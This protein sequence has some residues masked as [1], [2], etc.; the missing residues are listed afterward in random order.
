MSPTVIVGEAIFKIISME[1]MKLQAEVNPRIA[2]A[3]L[4]GA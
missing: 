1:A 3:L 4:P 2:N